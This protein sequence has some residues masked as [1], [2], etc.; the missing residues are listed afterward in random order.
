MFSR[1]V[2]VLVLGS[3]AGTFTI[4]LKYAWVSP[5][6]ESQTELSEPSKA[7]ASVQNTDE[8]TNKVV[9]AEEVGSST[10][11]PVP[12]NPPT[13]SP[14]DDCECI[15]CYISTDS[16]SAS[17]SIS[18]QPTGKGKGK[19]KKFPFGKRKS[20]GPSCAELEGSCDHKKL[21]QDYCFAAPSAAPSISSEPSA[22]MFPSTSPIMSSEPSGKGVGKGGKGGK[23]KG[24]SGKVRWVSIIFSLLASD[25]FFF[26]LLDTHMLRYTSHIYLNLLSVLSNDNSA[27]RVVRVVLVVRAVRAVSPPT[28]SSDSAKSAPL[29]I[30]DLGTMQRQ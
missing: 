1:K 10:A 28:F 22:S 11:S 3:G 4:D 21:C 20:K 26:S 16:P 15:Q 19:G 23:G 2:D 25:M 5:T 9:E 8:I 14:P 24:G 29:K 18:L 7:E 17:P 12:S 13:P 27:V 6:D 30:L